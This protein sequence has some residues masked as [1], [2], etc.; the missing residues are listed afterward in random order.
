MDRN[1]SYFQDDFMTYFV[2]SSPLGKYICDKELNPIQQ[3]LINHDS[4]QN[5]FKRLRT[6]KQAQNLYRFGPKF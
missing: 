2:N 3:M 5:P 6:L 1:S 4:A